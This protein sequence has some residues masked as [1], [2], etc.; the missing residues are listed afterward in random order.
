MQFCANKHIYI[1]YGATTISANGISEDSGQNQQDGHSVYSIL[2]DYGILIK[3]KK[4]MFVKLSS[5]IL[6][7]TL[8]RK[9]QI[10]DFKK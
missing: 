6:I 7:I 10:C 2:K 8:Q 3:D 4:E 9:I 5:D 1:S